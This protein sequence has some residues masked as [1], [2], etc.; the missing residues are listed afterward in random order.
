VALD[1]TLEKPFSLGAMDVQ[2]ASLR[3]SW[4]GGEAAL[5]PRVMQVLLVLSRAEGAVVSRDTLVRECWD[6]R[7]VGEDAVTRILVILRQLASRSGAFEVES[8]PKVG[9]RLSEGPDARTEAPAGPARPG[10]RTLILAGAGVAAA[11]GVAVLGLTVGRRR[12]GQRL[13]SPLTIA[14][15]PFDDL[16]P[17]PRTGFLAQGLARE[18]RNALSRVAGLRV[19]GDASSFAVAGQRLS[20]PEVGRRL[21]AELLLKGSLLQDGSRTRVTT[22]LVEARTGV[23]VWADAQENASGDLFQLRGVVASALIQQL[24]ARVGPDRLGTLPPQRHRHPEVFRIMLGADQLLE[25]TRALRMVG[26]ETAALDAADAAQSIVDKARALDPQDPGALVAQAA[27]VRNGW[28]RRLMAEPLTGAQRAA[29]AAELLDRALATDPN[30]PGALAALGDYYRRFEWRWSEAETL[31]RR[32]LAIDPNHL[33]AHWA[34]A[35]Q[36]ATLGRGVEGLE[37]ARA[38]NALDPETVWRRLALPRL[39]YLVGARRS[40]MRL[41]DAE[42]TR[43]PTNLFLLRELYFMGLSEF[44][45]QG[46]RALA[47]RIRRTL[48]ERP[49]AIDALLTRMDAGAQALTGRPEALV[50][51]VDADAAA[52]AASHALTGTVQGRASVDLL[53]IYAMEYAWAGQVAP[54]LELLEKALAARSLYWPASLP[55][56]VAQFPEPVRRHPEYAAIW[57]REPKRIALAR[58]RLTALE[59]GQMAGVLPNGRGVRSNIVS[60][61]A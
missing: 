57:R 25:Q 32:A 35:Y 49:P 2:P 50:R 28:T 41:Y 46:L 18:V 30:D 53:F 33:E 36:L 9:Y 48:A 59:Q 56:G 17:E 39:L 51:M 52:F 5:Q 12:A 27:L 43:G 44:D 15:M 26:Q 16:R 61:E 22:E 37:H 14:V 40:A 29:E 19:I 4:P 31:F 6:G 54:S 58:S 3:V 20:D 10:R 38:V 34:Y 13:E 47:A 1:L 60:G 24:I 45:A 8:L 42:L 23:Q 55:Y 7:F 21:G 11:A